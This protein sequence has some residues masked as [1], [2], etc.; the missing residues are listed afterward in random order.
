MAA[1]SR[2]LIHPHVYLYPTIP[3]TCTTPKNPIA[4]RTFECV[5]SVHRS[6]ADRN[7]CHNGPNP[8]ACE[9][10]NGRNSLRLYFNSWKRL[11][12][13]NGKKLK[14]FARTSVCSANKQTTV[15]LPMSRPPLLS[16]NHTLDKRV[17]AS[18]IVIILSLR[19]THPSAPYCKRFLKKENDKTDWR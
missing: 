1:V 16:G 15:N 5:S 14:S 3:N 2:T 10:F 12:G 8:F 19:R 4:L 13:G 6:R 17:P 7:K 9:H 11:T 18:T